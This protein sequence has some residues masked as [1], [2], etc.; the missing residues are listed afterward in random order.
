M[1]LIKKTLIILFLLIPLSSSYAAM[2]VFN[3]QSTINTKKSLDAGLTFIKY[4]G[5][6]IPT[7]RQICRDVLNGRYRKR[8]SNL[9]TIEEVRQ[10]WQRQSWSGKKSGDPLVVRGGYNCRHQWTYVNPYW[11]DKEGNLII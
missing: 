4:F 6:I 11:Y 9:F 5:D 3:Q 10:L 2:V 1:F 7:T 8:K